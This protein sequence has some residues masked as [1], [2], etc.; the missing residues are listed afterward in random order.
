M[1]SGEE[2]LR[3]PRAE[4]QSLILEAIQV[5]LRQRGMPPTVRELAEMC[6]LPKST[7]FEDLARLE[8]AGLIRFPRI[9]DGKRGARVID[10][11]GQARPSEQQVRLIPVR[12]LI[13]SSRSANLDPSEQLALPINLVGSGQLFILE[14]RQTAGMAS[15]GLL[16]GDLVVV[17]EQSSAG[18]GDLVV[19]LVEANGEEAEAAVLR[20]LKCTDRRSVLRG[21][22]PDVP[23]IDASDAR[24]LGVVIASLRRYHP[25]AGDD[26]ASEEPG[27]WQ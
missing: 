6:G 3:R 19:A 8:S 15:A 20:Y 11:V 18:H 4:R 7:V 23:A 24:M 22:D 13:G 1:V 14:V 25:S 10:L 9:Q 17:R 26:R 21:D 27:S 16:A 12:R 5:T 2:I